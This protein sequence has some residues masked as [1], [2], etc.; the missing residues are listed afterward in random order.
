MKNDEPLIIPLNDRTMAVLRRRSVVWRHKTNVFL[1]KKKPFKAANGAA[2][3][4]ALKRAGV[5]ANQR[6]RFHDLRHTFATWIVQNG[7]D[8]APLKRL[9]CWKSQ[10]IVDRYAKRGRPPSS[11]RHRTSSTPLC[12]RRR[13]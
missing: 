10:V 11:P 5:T 6:F 4:K 9:G 7:G 8:P 1:Y 13:N 2:W 12:Q 3:H